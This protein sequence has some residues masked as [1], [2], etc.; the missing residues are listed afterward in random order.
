MNSS[1]NPTWPK[2]R[3]TLTSAQVGIMEDWY[4]YWLGIM[5][6]RF[7]RVVDFNNSYALRTA[8][9][10]ARALEIGAGTGEH[11][12]HEQLE[13]KEYSALELR[14]NLAANIQ[15]KFPGVRTL[16][17]DCQETIDAADGYFDRVIA[18]H[19]LE[20]LDNLPSALNE[21]RRVLKPNGLFSIVIPCEGGLIYRLGRYVTSRRIFEK[22]YSVDYDW[23]INYDHI[24]RAEEIIHEV[25]SRFN[26]THR[27]FFPFRVP[28]VN[29]NLVL[30][31]TVTPKK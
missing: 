26:I 1:N 9:H 24:N 23:M 22:R 10:G 5:P 15:A 20:H 28:S 19:I 11:L 2:Q 14:G 29:A 16:V 18:I 6:S 17:G 25:S 7:S 27:E 8:G 30:G 3:P 31:M 12:R 13:G 4:S 21:V